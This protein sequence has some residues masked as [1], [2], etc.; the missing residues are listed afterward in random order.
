[1]AY[2]IIRSGG[3]QFR[4]E[5]DT[6]IRVPLISKNVGDAVEL[7]VL[8]FADDDGV[9]FGVPMVEGAKVSA[10]VVGHG[11]A[12]KII[13][14]KKKRRKQYKRTKG[15]RQD[16]TLIKVSG[17]GSSSEETTETTNT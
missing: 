12:D 10:N 1:M 8:S 3:K 7:E 16:Y 9:K 6:Q 2:A 14:F 13:V 5:Q 4:V 15:H 17:L 11:R